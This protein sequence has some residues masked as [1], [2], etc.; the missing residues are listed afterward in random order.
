MCGP[1]TRSV[2]AVAGKLCEAPSPQLLPVRSRGVVRATHGF[3]RGGSIALERNN[4]KRDGE[5]LARTPASR[6]ESDGTS[7]GRRTSG[8]SAAAKGCAVGGGG[9][10]HWCLLPHAPTSDGSGGATD[11]DALQGGELRRGTPGGIYHGAQMRFARLNFDNFSEADLRG[12]DLSA[13]DMYRAEF[14]YADLR[15]A[16]LRSANLREADFRGANLTRAVLMKANLRGADFRNANL[17][18]AVLLKANLRDA[19]L[20]GALLRG[21]DLQGANL[22]YADLDGALMPA[23]FGEQEG[24]GSVPGPG[25]R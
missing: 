20:A 3:M 18:Q 12:A 25:A 13:S 22:A 21:T 8:A 24:P 16:Q 15:D 6:P 2:G 23:G 17:T 10:R 4:S 5:G 14:R 9:H 1:H 19:D 11:R 7:P